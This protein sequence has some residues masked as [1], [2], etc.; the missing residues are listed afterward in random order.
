MLDSDWSDSFPIIVVSSS[1]TLRIV[2]FFFSFCLPARAKCPFHPEM[3][4]NLCSAGI[5]VR[6]V[7]VWC[8]TEFTWFFVYC[9][10][11]SCTEF[12]HFL[13]WFFFYFFFSVC[14][15]GFRYGV[16]PVFS[17]EDVLFDHFDIF[18][19]FQLFSLSLFCLGV[20]CL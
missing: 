8:V 9:C 5:C 13:N 7:P 17:F 15:E 16:F 3:L 6:G 14:D 18:S 1:V 4:H 12:F 20:L 2:R 11:R 19:Q 10:F